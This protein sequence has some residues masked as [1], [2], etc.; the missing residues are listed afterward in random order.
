MLIHVI[1]ANVASYCYCNSHQVGFQKV[2]GEIM[3]IS[4]FFMSSNLPCQVFDWVNSFP[5]HTGQNAQSMT[6]EAVDLVI[7]ALYNQFLG[8]R[9][10]RL[11]QNFPWIYPGDINQDTMYIILFNT[12]MLQVYKNTKNLKVNMQVLL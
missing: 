8:I 11:T 12:C 3:S 9:Y 2:F 6:K 4:K 1:E 7:L 5:K 10:T